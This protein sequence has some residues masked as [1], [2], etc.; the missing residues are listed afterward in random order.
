LEQKTS[1][2]TKNVGQ[3]LKTSWKAKADSKKG[4]AI[5]KRAKL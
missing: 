2:E 4:E 1:L 5:K 3:L